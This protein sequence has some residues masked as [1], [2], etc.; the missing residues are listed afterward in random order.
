MYRTANDSHVDRL[1]KHFKR[2]AVAQLDD[3]RSA[4][5]VRSRTTVFF[6]LKT[7]GSHTSYTHA[8]RFYT[9]A[10]IPRFDGNGLWV[11][12]EVRFSKHGTLRS[13]VVVLIKQ[14][15]G[16]RTHDELQVFLGLRVHDTL[17]SLV[18][19]GLLG[20]ERVKA[21]YVY[22]DPD[23]KRAA[24]QLKRR[25]EDA[26][27][28]AEARRMLTSE[29]T[30]EVLVDA[31]RE[32]PEIPPHTVVSKRLIARGLHIKPRLVLQVY[33][34]YGLEAGK[35]KPSSSIFRS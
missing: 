35:K 24:E 7:A 17:R 9:L 25:E 33:E 5:G 3:L 16:G 32:A 23:S 4:L 22:T 11:C 2:N 15:P 28:L 20:R 27:L 34:R 12:G 13:T 14:A 29:E 6:A 10:R 8:G 19:D 31:L 21:V 1:K 18:K 26:R 30:I